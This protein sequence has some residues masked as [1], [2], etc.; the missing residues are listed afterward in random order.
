MPIKRLIWIL[1]AAILF[2]GLV[3]SLLL[4]SFRVATGAMNETLNSGDRVLVEKWTLGSR[5]PNAIGLPFS[6]AKTRNMKLISGSLRIPGLSSL[7]R[8]DLIVF[9]EPQYAD[10]LPI[11]LRPVLISRCVGLP[12]EGVQ[13]FGQRLYI[14]R[15]LQKR[16][17]DALFCFCFD[18]TAIPSIQRNAPTHP[19]YTSN[20]TCFTFI[21]K[22]DYARLAKKDT[23]FRLLVHPY[24][25][26]YDTLK[27]F[28][29]Y[30]G[31]AVLLDSTSFN[32][33]QKLINAHEGCRL[34]RSKDGSYL[35]NGVRVKRYTFKQ[36]YYLVLN[37][38]QGFLN[39]SRTFGLV[40]SSHII[41]RALFILFSPTEN[42]FLE[43]VKR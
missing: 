42:R 7:C 19:F 38:H 15:S 23:A 9:N 41:G 25:S 27:T 30:K 1:L 6:E 8:N 32:K 34:I 4:D 31:M 28:I 5:M 22:H 13:L 18:S 40:P 2:A 29:P 12:G 37:D 26:R 16:G 39:D 20:D 43:L 11:N 14:N 35:L 10:S 21:T 36:D 3:R 24:I 33:W 17:I